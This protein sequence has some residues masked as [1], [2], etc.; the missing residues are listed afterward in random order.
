[1][2][3]PCLQ[4]YEQACEQRQ[5]G[6]YDALRVLDMQLTALEKRADGLSR[7]LLAAA[8]SGKLLDSLELV[9][10][11]FLN[12]ACM[13]REPDLQQRLLRDV[14][15]RVLGPRSQR[16]HLPS[17][18]GTLQRAPEPVGAHA[19]SKFEAKALVTEQ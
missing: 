14:A 10:R 5:G 15:H 4:A 12:V 3:G 19:W 16:C 18:R 8:F 11:G 9:N 2:P 17:G 7:A 1:M 6:A 13:I